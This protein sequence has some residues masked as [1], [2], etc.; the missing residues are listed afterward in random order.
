ME[1]TRLCPYM[2]EPTHVWA[3]AKNELSMGNS[4]IVS[5]C[6]VFVICEIRQYQRCIFLVK[7]SSIY[8]FM[9]FKVYFVL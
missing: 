1:T 3:H 2:L 6:E 5:H 7:E 9:L 4:F 8:F